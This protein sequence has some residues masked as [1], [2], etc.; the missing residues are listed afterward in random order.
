MDNQEYPFEEKVI[1]VLLNTIKD[2]QEYLTKEEN[3]PQLTKLLYMYNTLY[4]AARTVYENQCTENAKYKIEMCNAIDEK[5]EELIGGCWGIHINRL[6][7]LITWNDFYTTVF[8]GR[9]LTEFKKKNLKQN[10]TFEDW[11]DILTDKEYEFSYAYTDRKNIANILL[12]G[13]GNGFDYEN[14]Y[15]IDKKNISKYGDWE[16]AIFRED[17]QEIVKNIMA[18]PEVKKVIDAD[19]KNF[20]D[21]KK[22]F[23]FKK[24]YSTAK[25]IKNVFKKNYTPHK[26]ICKY[27][28]ISSFDENTHESYMNAAVEVCEEIIAHSNEET[29]KNIAFATQ[30]LEKFKK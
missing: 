15:V 8:E 2:N 26:E 25:E 28:N 22:F 6:L 13:Y 11:I 27:S 7:D 4:Y 21:V 1:D 3:I 23:D 10:K 24:F 9:K 19:V 18:I 17:I 20:Y 30:F 14:G 12:C 16:N 29:E 5:T